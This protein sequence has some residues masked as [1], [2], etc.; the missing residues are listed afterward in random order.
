[1]LRPLTSLLWVDLSIPLTSDERKDVSADEHCRARRFRFAHDR[2]RYLAAHSALRRSLAASGAGDAASLRFRSN[3]WG[4]PELCLPSGLY[5]NLSHSEDTG[6]IGIS[7]SHDIGVDVEILRH[8]PDA[9]ELVSEHFTRSE[10]NEFERLPVQERDRA[11]LVGWTRKE[12]CLKAIGSGLSVH[13]SLIEVGLTGGPCVVHIESEDE[14]YVVEVESALGP[15]GAFAAIA[16]VQSRGRRG[17]LN[18]S[19]AFAG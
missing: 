12:A 7:A 14:C 5:F 4:K 13:A 2:R 6:L 1:M 10:R 15:R 11:F 8:A 3:A 9:A 19:D 17:F 18:R 16:Q